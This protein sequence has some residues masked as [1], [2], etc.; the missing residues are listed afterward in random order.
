MPQQ[1]EQSERSERK[2]RNGDERTEDEEKAKRLS[3]G[4]GDG[5]G[6]DGGKGRE[7]ENSTILTSS[8]RERRPDTRG[9]WL[10]RSTGRVAIPQSPASGTLRVSVRES[11]QASTH[12]EADEQFGGATAAVNADRVLRQSAWQG[13]RCSR[14]PAL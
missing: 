5:D 3:G 8:W 11:G 1:V 12:A 2:R 9:S 13:N 6:G 4:G 14:P 7:M 10:G